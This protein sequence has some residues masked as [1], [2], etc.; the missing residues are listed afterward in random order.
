MITFYK[1]QLLYLTHKFPQFP[2][3]Y[4]YIYCSAVP[5]LTPVNHQNNYIHRSVHLE[6]T[7]KNILLQPS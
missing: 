5:Q 2:P 7:K 1:F 4:Y 3:L 6:V